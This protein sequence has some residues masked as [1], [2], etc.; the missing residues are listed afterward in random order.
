M[1]LSVFGL[2][3]VG[4]ISAACFADMGH[5]VTGVDVKPE[6]VKLF[7]KGKSPIVEPE[8][9]EILTRVVGQQRLHATTDAR[10]A[11]Q[12]T[13]I[14]LVC[15]GT[16][17]DKFGGIETGYLER[18]SEEI[19]KALKD[20]DDFHVIAFRSTM[21]P[22][23]IENKL[24]PAIETASGKTV[25]N[26]FGVCIIPEF[27]R[28]G[29]AVK[30]FYHPPITL[31]G[32]VDPKSSE[33][34]KELFSAVSAPVVETDIKTAAMIKY[35]N[36]TFHGLKI[37]FANEIGNFCKELGVDSH[38]VM[39]I[40]CMDKEL[41]LG[42]Y[43]LKPG[44]AFGGSCLTKDLRALLN[45]AHKK[46]LELPVLES[47]LKS[48]E[49]QI[50]KGFDIIER[51]GKKRIGLLGLSFKAGTDD[52]RESPLVILAERLIG[53]GYLVK[54]LDDNVMLARLIGANREYIEREI[55]HIADLLTSDPDDLLNH[56]EVIVVGNKTPG[57]K[58]ILKKTAADQVVIDLVRLVD[59]PND[60][61]AE[62]EGVCW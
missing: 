17:S 34:V 30:D 25:G 31:I 43:Y 35:A 48:N 54:V 2:G 27:L 12:Q 15:V 19:G 7:D 16:P 6:K 9:E 42:N 13:D 39:E 8:L 62:Y 44:F 24:I 53:K 5:D 11:V 1:K 40:F 23:T 10:A 26:G 47:L 28:E 4:C 41:N 58:H 57:F 52:L 14:S 45:L 61:P 51:Y 33:L 46:F 36:N 55:P 21:I 38:R 59:N 29:S 56:S 20:K 18:V 32:S 37:C 22:G 50:K 49:R 60:I 3:Y